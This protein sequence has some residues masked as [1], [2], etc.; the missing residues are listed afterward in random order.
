MDAELRCIMGKLEKAG[1][2]IVVVL[3]GVIL[4]VALL[5][6]GD[7]KP[8]VDVATQPTPQEP[9]ALSAVRDVDN[10]T[11]SAVVEV[12][13]IPAPVVSPVVAP[14]A[15]V[16]AAPVNIAP[17]TEPLVTP[18]VSPLASSGAGSVV[19]AA[20]KEVV[21]KSGDSLWKIAAREV[22]AREVDG[23][24]KE[25]REANGL[26]TN[27]RLK[28]GGKLKLPAHAGTVANAATPVAGTSEVRPFEDVKT[29][30]VLEGPVV[31]PVNPTAAREYTVKKG[32]AL[33]LIA[34]RECG[35][36]KLVSEIVKLNGLKDGNVLKIGQKLKLPARA[37]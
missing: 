15:D 12:K 20:Q 22:S 27:A 9:S 16:V 26:A 1:V 28:V 19:A 37:K 3:L 4:M 33:A 24:I 32:D 25:I 23:Y 5:G 35:S 34:Q 18:V 21:I 30:S 29:V 7:T 14:V 10:T 2:G 8:E 31:A 11:P 6:G 13:D 36:V 17:G